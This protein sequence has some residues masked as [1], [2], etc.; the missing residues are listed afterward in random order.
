MIGYGVVLLPIPALHQSS[1]NAAVSFQ[2][3]SRQLYNAGFRTLQQV[4]YADPETL[5]YS[6]EHMPRKA[7]R[8]IVA[9]AQVRVYVVASVDVTVSLCLIPQH[10]YVVIMWYIS[11]VID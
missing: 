7:A 1:L 3:R 9:A 2:G 6:I 4:A 5:V 8:Q 11:D 10:F